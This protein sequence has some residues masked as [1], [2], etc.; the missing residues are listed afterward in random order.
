MEKLKLH[1]IIIYHSSRVLFILYI[2]IYSNLSN[3]HYYLGEEG[4]A[5][6]DILANNLNRWTTQMRGNIVL[7]GVPIEPSKLTDRVAYVKTDHHFTPDMS[8][9]QTMLFHAFLREPGSHSRARDT[10]GM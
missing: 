1:S 10:K 6:C 5:L 3:L 2:P 9:R 7:N 8:V 4:T